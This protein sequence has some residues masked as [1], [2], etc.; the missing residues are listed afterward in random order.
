MTKPCIILKKITQYVGTSALLFSGW[1]SPL[2]DMN[3]FPS[4][5][6]AGVSPAFLII[7]VSWWAV[8]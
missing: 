1:V 6:G 4:M 2:V 5:A 8:S 7:R 3:P